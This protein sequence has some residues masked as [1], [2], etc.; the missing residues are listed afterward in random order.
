MGIGWLSALTKCLLWD[1]GTAT[2]LKPKILSGH[3]GAVNHGFQPRRAL[4]LGKRR[5]AVG[6]N[7]QIRRPI[8]V[9][10]AL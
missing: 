7:R 3:E 2:H 10:C 1:L 5:A 9:N 6:F 8:Q 4:S